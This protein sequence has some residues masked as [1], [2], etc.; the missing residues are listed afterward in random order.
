METK[1]LYG[2]FGRGVP[3]TGFYN[4]AR[5]EAATA[6]CLTER[7]QFPCKDARARIIFRSSRVSA[8]MLNQP[9]RPRPTSACA[10]GRPQVCQRR[11]ILWRIEDKRM[12]KETGCEPIR[13]NYT[14]LA[15]TTYG[16]PVPRGCASFGEEVSG[17]MSGSRLDFI[18]KTSPARFSRLPL[19]PRSLYSLTRGRP[20]RHIRAL[21]QRSHSIVF[22]SNVRGHVALSP[23]TAPAN[24]ETLARITAWKAS[25]KHF[26]Y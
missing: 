23:M 12:R 6:A 14:F 13:F 3:A 4:L 8:L 9:V 1:R 20:H 18:T 24:A 17:P 5:T 21:R 19:H 26:D 25:V 16:D 10:S 7:L 22:C 15:K 11:K 2:Y